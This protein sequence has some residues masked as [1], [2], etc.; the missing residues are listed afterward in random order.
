[1]DR[2][3]LKKR[4]SGVSLPELLDELRV[5]RDELQERDLLWHGECMVRRAW[6]AS[7]HRKAE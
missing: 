2:D 1:M 4:L 6:L 7:T 3:E 5:Y